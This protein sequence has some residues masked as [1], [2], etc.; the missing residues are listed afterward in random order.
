M[1]HKMQPLHAP[2]YG[3]LKLCFELGICILQNIML[4]VK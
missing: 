1:S 3:S 4:D 2:V